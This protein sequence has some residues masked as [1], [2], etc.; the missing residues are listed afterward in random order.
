MDIQLMIGN[1]VAIFIYLIFVKNKNKNNL[2]K[3]FSLLKDL[4]FFCVCSNK[5]CY[6]IYIFWWTNTGKKIEKKSRQSTLNA[7]GYS[8]I[9]GLICLSG[10]VLR[11]YLRSNC[12]FIT[13]KGRELQK[14]TL[15]WIR[16]KNRIY[17][18]IIFIIII[19]LK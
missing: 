7:S 15:W 11:E 5:N 2:K 9:T 18:R 4:L 1:I 8:Q 3:D 17:G 16:N 12:T 10:V 19:F 13:T 6:N 14:K